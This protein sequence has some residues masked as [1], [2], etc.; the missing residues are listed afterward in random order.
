MYQKNNE[1]EQKLGHG[2][3]LYN[4]RNQGN[5][6]HQNVEKD[7]SKGPGMYAISV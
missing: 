5:G 7:V 4:R 1:S 3:G 6:I 2:I